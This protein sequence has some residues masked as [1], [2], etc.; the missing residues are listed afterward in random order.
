MEFIEQQCNEMNSALLNWNPTTTINNEGP[1]VRVRQ[2][3]VVE[4]GPILDHNVTRT[5]GRLK[6]N[7]YR[8]ASET[9]GRGTNRRRPRPDE[10]V[11]GGEC[12]HPVRR[13]RRR[14]T[15]GRD[16]PVT[17]PN[18]PDEGGGCGR[19]LGKS[20]VR[21]NEP[22]DESGRGQGD[23]GARLLD[24]DDKVGFPFDLNVV[25]NFSKIA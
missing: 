18:E 24:E 9:H 10:P 6:E 1:S 8:S 7:R 4:G 19:G 20:D 16:E 17:R 21:L 3:I 13:A 5:V 12:P 15:H 23:E 14:G 11:E 25:P 2:S 22:V